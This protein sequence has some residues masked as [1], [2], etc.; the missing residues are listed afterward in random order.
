MVQRGKAKFLESAVAKF[1]AS[2]GFLEVCESPCY[3]LEIHP[4]ILESQKRRIAK[5]CGL[6]KTE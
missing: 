1:S 6:V 3:I 4:F 5:Y 2:L